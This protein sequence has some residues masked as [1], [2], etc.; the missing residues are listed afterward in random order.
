MNAELG[1]RDEEGCGG[2]AVAVTVAARAPPFPCA[3]GT[4]CV[5]VGAGASRAAAVLRS[6]GER[7][8]VSELACRDMSRVSFINWFDRAACLISNRFSFY[9]KMCVLCRG[10]LILSRP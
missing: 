5:A 9:I 8:R 1:D 3:G 10:R 6:M 2:A 7:A 4:G